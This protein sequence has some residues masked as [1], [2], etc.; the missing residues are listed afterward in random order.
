[1]VASKYSAL[2]GVIFIERLID[3]ASVRGKAFNTKGRKM[4]G[5]RMKGEVARTFGRL[6]KP[7][8]GSRPRGRKLERYQRGGREPVHGRALSSESHS[9]GKKVERVGAGS[10]LG[11]PSS[12]GSGKHET[13]KSQILNR[14]YFPQLEGR[15]EGRKARRQLAQQSQKP[16]STEG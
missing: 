9:G 4:A 3:I 13:K 11:P 14:N 2:G 12:R 15:I 5:G 7:E 6:L 16:L 1:V 8:G 10:F